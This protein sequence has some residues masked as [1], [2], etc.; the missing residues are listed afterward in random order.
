M[1]VISA[2]AGIIMY[3]KSDALSK[4][5]RQ[6]YEDEKNTFVKGKSKTGWGN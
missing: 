5:L 2:A 3:F 4:S 6:D 1:A